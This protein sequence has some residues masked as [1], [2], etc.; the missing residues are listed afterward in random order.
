[1]TVISQPCIALA[2]Q[3]DWISFIK[4]APNSANRLKELVSVSPGGLLFLRGFKSGCFIMDNRSIRG[5]LK[6]LREGVPSNPV[7]VDGTRLQNAARFLGF[8]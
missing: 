5:M 4:A 1:M 6:G 3:C 8:S 2:S 7:I